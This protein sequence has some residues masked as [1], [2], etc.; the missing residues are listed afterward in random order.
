[1]SAQEA[2]QGLIGRMMIPDTIM[3]KTIIE[4]DIPRNIKT[5]RSCLTSPGTGRD[6][7]SKTEMQRN[8][9]FQQYK[10]KLYYFNTNK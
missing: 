8:K 1:M 6:I 5:K 3:T 4:P 9:T 10:G 2:K 7:K